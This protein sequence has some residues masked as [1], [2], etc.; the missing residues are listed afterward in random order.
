MNYE[1]LILTLNILK[2]KINI[3]LKEKKNYNRQV[4]KLLHKFLKKN[5]KRQKM[6]FC[7]VSDF[8]FLMN[9]I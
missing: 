4:T 1:N 9:L 8:I 7:V 5:K 2:I 3:K 6:S